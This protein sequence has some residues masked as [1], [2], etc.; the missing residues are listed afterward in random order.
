MPK[1]AAFRLFNARLN[2]VNFLRTNWTNSSV[3]IVFTSDPDPAIQKN[4]G[5]KSSP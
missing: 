1:K 2:V 3:A 4:P 5:L